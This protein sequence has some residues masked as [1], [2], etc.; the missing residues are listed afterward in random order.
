MSQS[1]FGDF[2]NFKVM[3]SP[4]VIL[5]LFWLGIVAIVGAAV[6]EFMLAKIL[7]GIGILVLGPLAWR[8]VCEF[9]MVVF[10]NHDCLE[11]IAATAETESLQKS[12]VTRTQTAERGRVRQGKTTEFGVLLSE[13]SVG[14]R[15]ET[16]DGREFKV[17]EFTPDGLRVIFAHGKP[18]IISPIDP[19]TPEDSWTFEIRRS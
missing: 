4:V 13:I 2:L 16:V 10:R 6:A 19:G 15:F 3:I 18:E 1:R 11:R 12:A 7:Y 14:D 5:V 8:I 9:S 17:V